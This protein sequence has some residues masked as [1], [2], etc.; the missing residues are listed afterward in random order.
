VREAGDKRLAKGLSAGR[1]QVQR[2]F[3][4]T[5]WPGG[6]QEEFGGNR[7]TRG[8]VSKLVTSYGS[9]WGRIQPEGQAR[10]VFFNSGALAEPSRYDELV[11]G[12]RV[13]FEEVPDRA[14]GSQAIRVK[15]IGRTHSTYS[16]ANCES[17][18]AT[19]H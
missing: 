12:Q 14:N 9:T 8:C 7:M 5:P 11:L 15:L 19:V 13:E 2:R 3:L 4:L 1:Q 16:A 10:E 18:H 17:G 6:G